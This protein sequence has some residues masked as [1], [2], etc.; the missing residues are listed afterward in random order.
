MS[1]R[2]LEALGDEAGADQRL[3]H[4]AQDIV[5]VLP[6]IVA[7]LLAQPHMRA[8]PDLARD[9][10][11]AGAADQRVEPLRELAFVAGVELVAA[12]RRSPCPAPGRPGTPAAD[13]RA[14]ARCCRGSAPRATGPRQP[15]AG[16]PAR[17]G[18][19]GFRFPARGS[20]RAADAVP[21]RGG[22]PGPGLEPFGPAI[23]RPHHHRGA[24]D[25]VVHRHDPDPAAGFGRKAAVLR[26]VAVVAHQEHVAFGHD[27]RRRYRPAGCAPRSSTS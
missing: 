1:A 5:A 27:E 3:H 26:I 8:E 25:Q 20:E 13:N 18:K 14:H 6:A 11:A 24:A 9:R 22:E 17:S 21:A 2:R 23:G 19:R 15:G 16:P 4:V 7:G 10:G 12:I